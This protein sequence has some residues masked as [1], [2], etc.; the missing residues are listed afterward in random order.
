[1]A[2]LS[3]RA[4]IGGAGAAG[5][6]GIV[7]RRAIAAE[8]KPA[9][10]A[11][12]LPPRV[13]T[14]HTMTLNGA[15]LDY[16]A[17][18]ETIVL[19]NQKGE[20]TA[21][22]D[23]ISYL[24]DRPPANNPLAKPRPVAF[25]FNGGPGAA[26]VFLHLGALGPRILDT[27]DTGALPPPPVRLID[28]PL[29]WLTFTDLAFVDPVG[30]GFSHGEG[31]EDNP[32]KTF[33]N[34]RSDL[35]SL[36][37]VIRRWLIRHDRW[38]APVYLV[39]ESYGGL[40]A[41]ALAHR[42]ERDIGLTPSGLVL[43]SPALDIALLRP[44]VATL[45]GPAALLPSCAAT[46][47]A[48]AGKPAT[49]AA[50]DAEHFALSEYLV[51]LA[52]LT[53]IPPTGD[54]LIARIAALTGLSEQVVR[55]ARGR[56]SGGLFAHEFRRAEHQILSL[57]DATV[58]RPAAANP[59]DDD[60]GDPVLDP[61]V[62]A[63]TSAFEHYAIEELWYRSERPYRVLAEQVSNQWNW[64]GAREGEAGLGAA[65]ASLQ[66]ALLAHPTTRVLIAHGRYDLVTPY[67][68]SRWLVDQL[69]IP[70]NVRAGIV[71]RVY[72]GGH[73]MYNRPASRAALTADAAK[74]FATDGA[75]HPQ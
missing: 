53:G 40:R 22:I 8:D 17:I 44:D 60:A 21:A 24:A 18:A 9:D 51:G 3:R 37:A 19:T 1:L 7:G 29:T 5:L 41:A 50:E 47:A 15:S 13:E 36:G 27:P 68:G 39:G 6:Y 73:M 67:F 11:W 56:L 34:V 62:A 61:A 32:D 52:R 28:N 65:L 31:K 16:H 26:S 10:P 74:L 66:Q 12:T 70:P 54:P 71:L 25:V 38:A 63:F 75:A 33:W 23:T 4:V 58:T 20:P 72:E 49:A 35:E 59:W 2:D 69:A 64:D 46:A 57:Y 43:I 48:F 30:T 55:D 14:R 42:L 45:L